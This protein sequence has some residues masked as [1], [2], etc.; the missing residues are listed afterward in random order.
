[1]TTSA[2][3]GPPENIGN[4]QRYQISI[5]LYV[6]TVPPFMHSPGYHLR[7]FLQMNPIVNLIGI[8]H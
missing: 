6:F 8:F 3:H 7:Q 2:L 5:Y 1:M 4:S